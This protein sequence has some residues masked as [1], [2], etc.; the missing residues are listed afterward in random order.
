MAL[1][2][3]TYTNVNFITIFIV[4]LLGGEVRTPSPSQRQTDFT[5]M[6]NN[7]IVDKKTSRYSFNP[8]AGEVDWATFSADGQ[9]IAFCCSSQQKVE[10][11]SVS[12]F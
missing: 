10:V 9:K 12:I 5:D 11:C 2:T 6:F 3:F 4:V 8:N 1:Y 7:K